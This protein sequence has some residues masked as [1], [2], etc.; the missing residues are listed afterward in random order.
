MADRHQTQ[1]EK[2][3]GVGFRDYRDTVGGTGERV[4]ES[5][6]AVMATLR[7]IAVCFSVSAAL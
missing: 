7:Q 1:K 2:E 4:L 5:N 6:S 3:Q